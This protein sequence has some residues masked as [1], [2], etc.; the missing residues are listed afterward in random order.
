M[1][2]KIMIRCDLCGTEFQM[3][4]HRYDGKW[5]SR[6]QMSMCRS[7]FSGN[8]DGIGPVF[9]PVFVRHLESHGIDLPERNA[10][11]W[12]PRGH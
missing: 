6:Y 10:Q 9:E 3:G 5:I 12:F 1:K 4:P 7:C 11:G 2:P 8:W